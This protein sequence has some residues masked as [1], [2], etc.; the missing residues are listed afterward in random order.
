[1]SSA[2]V[3]STV[4][5]D[6]EIPQDSW[7]TPFDPTAR[8]IHVVVAGRHAKI[9]YPNDLRRTLRAYRNWPSVLLRRMNLR[10]YPVVGKL[11]NG[12]TARLSGNVEAVLRATR[13]LD[14]IDGSDVYLRFEGRPVVVYGG[15]A[16]GDLFCTFVD[17][18]YRWL[19]VEGR[20][21]VDIGAATGDSPIYFALRG[22]KRVVGFEPN[23]EAFRWFEENVR[24]NG[25]SNVETVHTIAPPIE[26][27]V[28]RYSIDGG[29]L[30]MD[31]EGA[32]YD[33]IG[34]A[35]DDVLRRFT[36]VLLEYHWGPKGIPAKLRHAGF[37]VGRTRASRMP[38]G[39]R[40]GLLWAT[41]GPDGGGHAV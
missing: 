6:S 3:V 41:R 7:P 32:E 27:I 2:P 13:W 21:V 26:E 14:R 33:L 24:A 35:P 5:L 19:P 9:L 1:M 17:Q 40:I 23:D 36:H 18:T 15:L 31:C 22:A 16:R 39:M 30:K 29:I 8:P 37:R 12:A 34:G 38:S 28:D 25:L 10:P 4:G 11:R 20:S